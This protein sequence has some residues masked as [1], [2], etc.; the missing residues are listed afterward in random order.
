MI[1]MQVTGAQQLYDRVRQMYRRIQHFKAIDIGQTMSQWQ[2][3]DLHRNRPFTMRWKRKGVAQTKVRPHS[4]YEVKASLAN[5]R[6]LRRHRLPPRK[7]ST[8]PIL[9]AT[10]MEALVNRLQETMKRCIHW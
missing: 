5:E 1:E 4:L 7:W 8:R 9:R 3:Q 6:Y 10:M 2:T